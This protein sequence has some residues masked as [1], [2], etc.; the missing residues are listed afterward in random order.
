MENLNSVLDLL[1]GGEFITTIDLKDAYFTVP[2]HPN[3]S[4]YLRFEWDSRLFEFTCLPFGLSS[5]PRVFTKVMKPIVAELRGTG[6]MVVIYLDD[7]AIISPNFDRALADLRAT[8]TLLE[9]LGFIINHE[10]SNFQPSQVVEY[11]GFKI[12]SMT[13][14]VF[15]PEGKMNTL[16]TKARLLYNSASCTIR[17]VAGIIGLIVSVFP[18]IKPAKLYYRSL[19]SFKTDALRLHSNN[20]DA[21]VSLTD[22]AKHDLLWFI[23]KSQTYNGTSP[24][25]PT[26]IL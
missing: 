8:I 14:Q 25:K 4:K 13:M 12:N 24:I 26:N 18:A 6:I 2:I 17:D 10:K 5:A 7:L 19:D 22:L 21:F 3:H 20:Y 1:N 23:T 16:V 9:S 15:L 11:L